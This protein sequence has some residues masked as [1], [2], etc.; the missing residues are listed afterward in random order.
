MDQFAGL[1]TI[2]QLD[3]AVMLDLQPLGQRSNGCSLAAGQA[4][5][6]QQRL[7]LLRFQT[8]GARCFFAEIEKSPDLVAKLPQSLNVIGGAS[9]LFHNH[10]KV[11]RITM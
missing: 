6:R 3:R 7:M 2:D 4:F 1:Q 5:H 9:A 10:R 11:Y 8:C